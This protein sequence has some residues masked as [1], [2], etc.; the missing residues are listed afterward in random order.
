MGSLEGFAAIRATAVASATPVYG[1]GRGIQTTFSNG[2]AGSHTRSSPSTS[3]VA[4][5]WG[6]LAL[7]RSGLHVLAAGPRFRH[8]ALGAAHAALARHGVSRLSGQDE[9]I[10]PRAARRNPRE[11]Y[12]NFATLA[13]AAAERAPLPDAITRLGI[14]ALVER[15]RRDAQRCRRGGDAPALPRLCA[16]CRLP[17]RCPM[18]MRSTT[19]YRRRSSTS[20]LARSE[21]TPA[22]CSPTRRLRWPTQKRPRCRKPR[23]AP[24][25]SDGQHNPRTGVRLGLAVLVDGAQLSRTRASSRYRTPTRSASTSNDRPPHRGYRIS[26]S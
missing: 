18:P 9:R 1:A 21:S 15:T 7:G 13:A 16:A 14:A 11:A 23:T 4:Y 22:A 19:R 10:F 17:R 26:R 20:C 2:S 5:P 8:P 12:M 24:A 6:W 25:C 3:S